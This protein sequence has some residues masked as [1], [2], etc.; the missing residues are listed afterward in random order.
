[1]KLSLKETNIIEHYMAR[2]FLYHCIVNPEVNLEFKD[3][4]KITV[5]SKVKG[6]VLLG[7]HPLGLNDYDP[8]S[9]VDTI[10]ALSEVCQKAT[11]HGFL[12]SQIDGSGILKDYH[13]EYMYIE[14]IEN[15]DISEAPRIRVS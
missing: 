6:I 9:L 7:R 11:V 1:M 12:I 15:I 4:F 5:S 14:D 3:K 10:V 13:N 8:H 2:E